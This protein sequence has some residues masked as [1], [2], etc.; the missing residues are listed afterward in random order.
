MAVIHISEE[1]AAKNFSALL[2]KARK[3]EEIIIEDD[4][5]AVRVSRVASVDR[6]FLRPRYT[7]PRLLSDILADLE[8][9]PSS[10]RMTEGFANDVEAVIKSH[11]NEMVF[12]PWAA[13]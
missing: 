6:G 12:D 11:E 3:G 7:A 9:N 10:A 13:S 2:T 4:L 8:A 1:E 5:G